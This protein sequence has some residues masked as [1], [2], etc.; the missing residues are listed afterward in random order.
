MMKQIKNPHLQFLNLGIILDSNLSF[1]G[2]ISYISKSCFSNICDLPRNRNTL[3]HKTACTIATSLI[4]SKLD[5]CNSLYPNIS[6][7]KLNRLQL[8]LNSAARAV[9]KPPK[10]HHIYPHLKSLHWLEITQRIQHKSLSL[11]YYKSLQNNKPS[12]ISDFLTIQPKRSTRSLLQM[13][14][15]IEV[16]EHS[17]CRLVPY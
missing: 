9:A 1:S 10:F 6:S 16:P 17:N 2:H 13:C 14:S 12:S 11:T 7:Q 3:D 4:H 15:Q 8:V 5:Y